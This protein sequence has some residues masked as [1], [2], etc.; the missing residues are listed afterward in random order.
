M[1]LRGGKSQYLEVIHRAEYRSRMEV[2]LKVPEL[3]SLKHSTFF[4][5]LR[6]LITSHRN[7]ILSNL[8]KHQRAV[9]TVKGE[10]VEWL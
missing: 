8:I 2:G 3:L 6:P 9:G 10:G 7:A 5:V 1:L 4:R